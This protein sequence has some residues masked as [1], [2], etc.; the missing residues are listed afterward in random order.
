MVLWLVSFLLIGVSFAEVGKVSKILGDSSAHV[1]RGTA[2]INLTQDFLINEGD[3]VFSEQSIVQLEI[4]PAVEVSLSKNSQIKMTKIYLNDSAEVG[5]LT[6]IIGFVKGLIRLKVTKDSDLEVD[7]RVE[8]DSVVFGVRGTEF[9]V[10]NENSQIDLDVVE[11]EVEVS[12]P[13]IQTFVPEIV[14]TNQGFR[15]SKKARSFEKRKFRLKF[16]DH[17]AFG[18]AKA[19]I[20]NWRVKRTIQ[21]S[22]R[23]K[24]IHKAKKK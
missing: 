7:Q 4:Y 9:E 22:F 14:K 11:G 24:I 1:L 16:K 21:R 23:S 12:S 10:S 5:K 19:R 3:E 15:F 20:N 8:A 2:K 18:D 17:P 6:S 13:L